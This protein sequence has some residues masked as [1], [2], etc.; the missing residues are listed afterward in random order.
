[1]KIVPILAILCACASP[2]RALNAPPAAQSALHGVPPDG[3][4]QD[5][6]YWNKKSLHLPYP[7]KGDAHATL[8][9]WGP[10]GYYTEK[11]CNKG[12]TFSAVA[13]HPFGNPSGYMHVIYAFAA[14]T[15]G[16][17]LCDFSAVLKSTGSPPIAAIELQ[18]E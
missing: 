2:Q 1:M 4:G 18:I 17:E 8:T 6:I 5:N 13:G 9:Y 10:N 15:R 16:S 12:G 3:H 14:K 11:Y 7:P